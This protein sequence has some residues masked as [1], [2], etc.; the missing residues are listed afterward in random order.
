MG[1]AQHKGEGTLSTFTEA[2]QGE[3]AASDMENPLRAAVVVTFACFF[4]NV[5][6]NIR[7]IDMNNFEHKAAL[8]PQ[9]DAEFKPWARIAGNQHE[10]FPYALVIFW[11]TIIASSIGLGLGRTNIFASWQAGFLYTFL[12]A[13]VLFQALYAFQLQPWR[14][15]SFVIGQISTISMAVIAVRIAFNV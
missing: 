5:F 10:N 9:E 1:R 8:A 2:R 15:L 6:A 12:G 14:S 3:Q 13:R 7:N 11:G 4:L